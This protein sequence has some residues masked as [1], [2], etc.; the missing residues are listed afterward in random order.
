MFVS[1]GE[2]NSGLAIAGA[3]TFPAGANLAERAGA[4][5]QLKDAEGVNNEVQNPAR[6]QAGEKFGPIPNEVWGSD[7]LALGV[8]VAFL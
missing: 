2:K 8:E 7:H 3:L 5:T 6:N 4:G 1:S